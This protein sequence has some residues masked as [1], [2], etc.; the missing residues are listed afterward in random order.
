MTNTSLR[1]HR[2][3]L[4][5]TLI[6][7]PTIFLHAQEAK[8]TGKIIGT[9]ACYDTNTGGI[10][11]TVNT[12]ANAFDGNF[13]TWVTT[14]EKSHTWVG[15]DLGTPH[16][17][18]RVG[19]SPKNNSDGPHRVQLGIFE[20]SNRED[21]MDAVPLYMVTE[22]STI[23][24]M[25]YADVDVSRGFRYVRWCGPANSRCSVSELEFWGHEG[26]GDDSHF[27]QLSNI[28]TLSY[29]TYCGKEPWDK[30]TELESEMCIIYE[31]GSLIQEYPITARERG[32]GSRHESMLKRPYRIKF[33]D[34]KSH[35]MLKGST[36][37][38]PAKSRKW[39]L[40]PNW[41]EKTL[42]RNN[43]AF[44]MSR[45][46]GML[47]TPWIQNVDVIVNGEYKGNYQLCDQ[48]T[49]DPCRVDID[50]LTPEDTEEPNITGGYLLE[51]DGYA[52]SE[53]AHF[54]SNKNIP[55]T[56]KYPDSDDII[57]AQ[58]TYI[59]NHFNKMESA[60]WKANFK[61]KENGYRR[62]MDV[63]SFLQH[64]LVNEFAGNH[65]AYWSVYLYKA[66]EDDLF[67]FGPTWD[68]DL[69]MDNDNQSYPTC[70]KSNWLYTYYS[71]GTNMRDVVSRVLSDP[72]AFEELKQ[73]WAEMRESGLF[74]AES[75]FAYIDSLTSVIDR[76][77]ELNFTR[78]DVLKTVLVFQHSAPGTYKGEIDLVKQYL[79]DRIEWIDKKLGYV[80]IERIDP[81]DT[82]YVI[83]TPQRFINYMR[84]VNMQ[85]LTQLNALVT[86]DLDLSMVKDQLEPIGTTE[87]PFS[88]RFD[89]QNHI[90]K[91]LVISQE[92]QDGVGLFGTVAAG[93][94]IHGITLDAS[95]II[96][97]RN[98]VGLIGTTQG[99]GTVTLSSLANQGQVI[100][101]GTHA[102][103]ILGAC[104]NSETAID[105]SYCYTTGKVI[106]TEQAGAIAG[107]VGEKA[108]LTAC[109]SLSAVQGATGNKNF[110][111]HT[112][113]KFERCY[114]QTSSIQNGI[115][116]LSATSASRGE[117]CYRLNDHSTGAKPVFFQ[118]L[119]SDDF[120]VLQRHAEVIRRGANY[121]NND[122]F[123]IYTPQ[124]MVDFAQMVNNGQINLKATLAADIDLTGRQIPPMGYAERP[125]QGTFDGQGHRISNL[126]IKSNED[127]TG[128]FRYIGPGFHLHDIVFDATC[129]ISGGSYVGIAAAT[130]DFKGEARFTRVG[131][132]GTINGVK[133]AGA[134]FG[135]QMGGSTLLYIDACYSSGIV[136]GDNE[137]G[138]LTGYIRNG[139]IRNCWTS[140]Q[141]TGWYAVAD[142]PFALLYCTASNNYCTTGPL[143]KEFDIT[144]ISGE[145]VENGELCYLLNQHDE[146]ETDVWFQ[147]LGSDSHPV[148]DTTHASVIKKDDGSYENVGGS[149]I[150]GIQ[151]TGQQ[152]YYTPSGVRTDGKQKGLHIVIS[153]DGKVRKELK[154]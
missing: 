1:F 18:T 29:H 102:G 83:D 66:R 58:R 150:L 107:W 119:G 111:P 96:S 106:A 78:W 132:E 91:G 47:Y 84:A 56:I 43:I 115:T 142:K 17:I 128:L 41:R 48:V 109:Y 125:Y 67:H 8:L 14:Y 2:A 49:I 79:H 103:G 123:T 51:I 144:L 61:D 68:F 64:F 85:G 72:D 9:E 63:R 71:Q 53:P 30:T 131:Y 25:H 65:D 39:V 10:T 32:N 20:G 12:P 138:A 4:A 62:Y 147:N 113:G 54:Y 108:T 146:S 129:S 21:F 80:Y 118:N 153:P 89:G 90:I 120:P 40:M 15:L 13:N 44:E 122:E 116:K 31:D 37:E 19:W 7:F 75:M 143:N 104:G 24:T 60:L 98:Q 77:V 117:L 26:E 33:N 97:G 35:H 140:A 23:G 73:M 99:V 46:L 57:G 105:M 151:H 101:K 121:L 100:A 149:G 154:R 136:T 86:A 52:S 139:E 3:L 127:F 5:L 69:S 92:K 50:D 93:A 133:N 70:N 45:R 94:R 22:Q 134:L 59:R 11:T 145:Q 95:C 124:D 137:S 110:A 126:V 74:T 130:K 114:H 16:V 87:H 28:P 76:S 141:I 6:L 112:S 27:Y 38:S 55:V 148:F 152:H 42:I 88:A 34:G 81:N 135:C 82:L 36:I